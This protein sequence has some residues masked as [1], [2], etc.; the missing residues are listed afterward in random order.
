MI[1]IVFGCDS[2]EDKKNKNS[3]A[4]NADSTIVQDTVDSTVSQDTIQ[5]MDIRPP[6]PEPG[7][8]PG[9]ARITGLFL[10]AKLQSAPAIMKVEV[11][12][13]NEYGSSTPAI[14]TGVPLT[15]LVPDFLTK[16]VKMLKPDKK[17]VCL[18]NYRQFL[19]S[20]NDSSTDNSRWVL[21][22]ISPAEDSK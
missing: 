18:L 5:I 9:T 8:P 17:I 11:I 16:N 12:T 20:D 6:H 7:L 4:Q 2:S 13:V 10:G 19:A 21:K 15:V 14:G 3:T 1:L 22:G